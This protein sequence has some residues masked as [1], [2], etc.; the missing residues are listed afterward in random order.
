MSDH[1]DE[2]V[3]IVGPS[4]CVSYTQTDESSFVINDPGASSSGGRG[5][6]G[7]GPYLTTVREDEELM[8]VS[9]EQFSASG[10]TGSR[11]QRAQSSVGSGLRPRTRTM[12]N[13][14][15]SSVHKIRS[16][17]QQSIHEVP[18]EDRNNS[19]FAAGF[20]VT[21]LVQGIGI[22][23]VPYAVSR[24]SWASIGVICLVAALCCYTGCLLVDCLYTGCPRT[25][26][27]VR[28][29]KSYP[30]VGA[31]VWPRFGRRAVTIV[32]V[33]EMFGGM[34]LYII[35]LASTSS[36]LMKER[37][38]SLNIYHWSCISTYATLPLTFITRMS[39]ISWFSM[40][41]VASLMSSIVSVLVFCFMHFDQ[42]ALTNM[43]GFD[44]TSFPVS[45]GIIVFSYCAH[46]VFPGIEECMRRPNSYPAML[47][48]S[49]G[50][51]A[52]VKTVMGVM[53]VLIF[54]MATEQE[55]GRN[56]EVD[57]DFSFISNSLIFVNV[58]FSMPLVIFVVIERFDATF[59]GAFHPTFH[60][61][62]SLHWLWIL[63]TRSLIM[64]AG[65]F[66]S[67]LVPHFALLMGLVGSFTG[68]CL[69]F[70]F[71]AWFHLVLKRKQLN[72]FGVFVRV[73]IILFGALSGAVG[74]FFSALELKKKL[75]Q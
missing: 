64:T 63:L 8:E 61:N 14:F 44:P 62:G 42:L 5:R 46:A 26:R 23:G 12:S 34:C 60:R 1:G 45:F 54:G 57:A 11:H 70:I 2:K 53:A 72:A 13:R 59:L 21:N 9:S 20:N 74:M 15:M 3:P 50:V 32:S 41:A 28:Y 69:C 35:L 24:G 56:L 52:I 33:V 27:R 30:D 31:M 68:T 22:M 71:P 39:F 4:T 16:Y 17:T 18:C 66:L 67:M 58:F 29:L 10:V 25:G 43:P 38:P 19:A 36:S 73:C 75:I 51:A 6:A 7:T 49:F 47:T 37:V 40:L 65:L 48:V 55:F